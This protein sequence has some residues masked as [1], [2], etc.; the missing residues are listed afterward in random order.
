LLIF[1]TKIVKGQS[2]Q[3]LI[4]KFQIHVN[5]IRNSDYAMFKSQVAY[6]KRYVIATGTKI[7]DP[8][9][10]GD[11]T[12][13]ENYLFHIKQNSQLSALDLT[14]RGQKEVKKQL[15]RVITSKYHFYIDL[16]K[17]R[18]VKI[19]HP[20]PPP[21]K[22]QGTPNVI[23][24]KGETYYLKSYVNNVLIPRAQDKK[25]KALYKRADSLEKLVT[26]LQGEL[27]KGREK[28]DSLQKIIEKLQKLNF[29]EQKGSISQTIK[30]LGI[31]LNSYWALK[32]LKSENGRKL[33]RKE[34][35]ANIIYN[36]KVIEHNE[37]IF[38]K[39]I[40]NHLMPDAKIETLEWIKHPIT[41]RPTIAR[42]ADS[43]ETF[44]ST[45]QG[46]FNH[47]HIEIK[48]YDIIRIITF[49]D[50]SQAIPQ[51]IDPMEEKLPPVR[52]EG[53]ETLDFA[54]TFKIT[55]LV[56]LLRKN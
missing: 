48:T 15:V 36:Q 51:K 29:Q 28:N 40:A 16:D 55:N 7:Y 6:L 8:K 26:R 25:Y 53:R 2:P 4:A 49:P 33:P 44:F 14:I 34:R 10:T 50:G 27:V 23:N 35:E 38:T 30:S 47:P 52:K 45:I 24:F 20:T 37:K 46:H 21:Q 9:F 19:Q 18:I 56:V 54:Q 17:K 42:S 32:P 39:D 13:I 22:I 31:S 3:Q 12:P 5:A 41:K 43:L 1:S 11:F